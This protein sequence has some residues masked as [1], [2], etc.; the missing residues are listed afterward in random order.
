M[1]SLLK[2]VAEPRREAILQLVW[3]EEKSAGEIAEAMPEVT[4]GAV[5]QHL[6]V[7]RDANLVGQRREGRHQ[8]YRA[9]REAIGLL[10][11]YLEAQWRMR[12]SSLKKAAEVVERGETS[13]E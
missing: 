2:T 12:L 1:L 8:F 6:K 4:F 5:S 11:E 13:H 10:A 9:R 7:L 3:L